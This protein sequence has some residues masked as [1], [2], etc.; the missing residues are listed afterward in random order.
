MNIA[1]AV[2]QA[3]GA[4]LVAVLPLLIVGPLGF[5]EI[6]NVI[7]V[8]IGAFIVYNTKNYPNW[9]YGKALA[10]AATAL[11]TGLVAITS[12]NSFGD[13]S[14]QQWWQIVI[15][16]LTA[17]AVYFIPNSGY[18]YRDAY[19]GDGTPRTPRAV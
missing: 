2:V 13:V 19:A 7:V 18:A 4:V 17:L 12:Y 11:T 16:I 14:P 9:R 10:S 15:S 1:K 5:S 3:L 8:A 6:V